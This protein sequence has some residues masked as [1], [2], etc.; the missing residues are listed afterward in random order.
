[1]AHAEGNNINDG[2]RSSSS[3]SSTAMRQ[4]PI[5]NRLVRTNITSTSGTGSAVTNSAY[6][7]L[8]LPSERE[9]RS[10]G[11]KQRRRRIGE[12]EL[13]EEGLYQSLLPN[14][15][16]HPNHSNRY[17]YPVTWT[18]IVAMHALQYYRSF[19][20]VRRRQR[21]TRGRRTRRRR[22]RN[23]TTHPELNHSSLIERK[24]PWSYVT[25]DILIQKKQ[26]YKWCL[27]TL[28][29]QQYCSATTTTSEF[30]FHT[31]TTT[32]A[33]RND[34]IT[35]NPREHWWRSSSS[36][37]S[38]SSYRGGSATDIRIQMQRYISIIIQ[39]CRYQ[40]RIISYG[41]LRCGTH[42]REIVRM[43]QRHYYSDTDRTPLER[44]HGL[45]ADITDRK[46]HV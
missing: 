5:P 3:A 9:N 2:I 45:Y 13:P 38:N 19:Y 44:I 1:M 15:V 23:V 24:V 40:F 31:T 17:N 36:S 18:I 11:Y 35:G 7:P 43:L 26:W 28:S 34:D 30:L 22:R 4:P 25:Y 14:G 33:V 6:H 8:T 39:Q 41:I 37:R 10:I 29:I 16:T 12:N 27:S 42:L 20:G 32:T 46:A 21:S